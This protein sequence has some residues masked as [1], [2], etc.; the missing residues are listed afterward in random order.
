MCRHGGSHETPRKHAT[1]VE[2]KEQGRR[3]GKPDDAAVTSGPR[4]K[5]SKTS[6]PKSRSNRDQLGAPTPPATQPR[7]SR[8]RNER[9]QRSNGSRSEICQ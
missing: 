9:A 6:W 3:V 5:S 7:R 8:R 2:A 1:L 4:G